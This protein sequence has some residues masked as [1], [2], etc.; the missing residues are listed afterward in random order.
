MA[1]IRKRG[2]KWQVQV[3]RL[4]TTSISKSFLKKADAQAWATMKPLCVSATPPCSQFC[5][6]PGSGSFTKLRGVVHGTMFL[7]VR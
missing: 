2:D 1:T 4:G 7:S 5:V 6:P 3:R